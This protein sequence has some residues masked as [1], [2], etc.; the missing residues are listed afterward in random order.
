M[1]NTKEQRVQN[2]WF[3]NTLELKLYKYDGYESE[4]FIRDIFFKVDSRIKFTKPQGKKGDKGN[5]MFNPET[6]EYYQIYSPQSLISKNLEK[7]IEEDFKKLYDYWNKIYPI[8]KYYFVIND[9][10]KGVYPDVYKVLEKIKNTYNVEYE[11][12]DCRKIKNI[13]MELSVD[14]KEDLLGPI[15]LDDDLI[16]KLDYNALNEVIEY[17]INADSEEKPIDDLKAIKFEEKLKINNLDNLICTKLNY[18]S[19]YI[20][21]LEAYFNSLGNNRRDE[22]GEKLNEIYQE[23]KKIIS[24]NNTNCGNLRF[25]YI[26]DKCYP[27]NRKRK[28]AINNA[29]F[30]LLSYYFETCSILESP[31][32]GCDKDAD[33]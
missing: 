25:Y 24:D 10:F 8:K 4:C 28:N 15:L 26:F 16:E 6:G 2:S 18:G 32:E 27:P 14:D 7:K 29:L 22:I 12:I 3:S 13:F 11:L 5:D 19:Y 31:P 17:I 20:S 30:I 1:E 21:S 33:S 23:A 9:K